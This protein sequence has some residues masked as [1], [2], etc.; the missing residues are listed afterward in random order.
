[1]CPRIAK[2]GTTSVSR[3]LIIMKFEILRETENDPNFFKQE[4]DDEYIV[5][6]LLMVF[7]AVSIPKLARSESSQFKVQ[8]DS[9]ANNIHCLAV[10]VNQIFGCLF[11]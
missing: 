11:R 8:L 3:G 7:V 6:C 4:H 5:S 2:T 10:A 9:H 1:M